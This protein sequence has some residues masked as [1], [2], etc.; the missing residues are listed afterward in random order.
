MYSSKTVL[1]SKYCINSASNWE[2]CTIPMTDLGPSGSINNI[3]FSQVVNVGNPTMYYLDD[4]SFISSNPQTSQI[5][6]TST[7]PNRASTEPSPSSTQSNVFINSAN[8]L[9]GAINNTNT[10]AIGVGVGVGIFLIL[11]VLSI[12]IIFFIIRKR[13]RIENKEEKSNNLELDPNYR[14]ISPPPTRNS[15]ELS[16]SELLQNQKIENL[17]SISFNGSINR[18]D[19]TWQ[20]NYKEINLEEKIGEG[21]YSTVFKGSYR[22]GEVAVKV[23]SGL[24]KKDFEI[25]MNEVTLMCSIRPQSNVVQFLGYCIHNSELLLVTELCAGGS[26]FKLIYSSSP[27]E[28]NQTIRF[29]KGIASGLH[30]LHQEGII[31][32]DLAARNILLTRGMDIKISDF[33]LSRFVQSDHVEG[34]KTVAD[35]GPV[36]WM[37]PELLSDRLY[38]FKSD[39]WS[40]GVVI[41]EVVERKLPYENLSLEQ[42]A[43]KVSTNSVSL[44]LSTKKFPKLENLMKLCLNPNSK[45]R[46]E[47][48]Q[49]CEMLK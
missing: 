48:S 25:Y 33:G 39:V 7:Q 41:Y 22:S 27:I 19:S 8:G 37:S 38:S 47:L 23:L 40:F 30:H 18:K 35:I 9:I 17:N 12:F 32:R 20:L 16:T 1:I 31:H 29:I 28:P 14:S 36:R 10:I 21:Y 49:I 3:S 2:E 44:T 5:E 13:K 26:L 42:V 24:T 34:M 45:Q 15:I 4:L 11:I 46:P 6:T 43:S